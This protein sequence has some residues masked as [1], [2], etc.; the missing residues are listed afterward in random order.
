MNISEKLVLI[1]ENLKI[2]ADMINQG[3]SGDYDIGYIDGY[4]SGWNDGYDSGWWA[5][6]N[7]YGLGDNEGDMDG[8]MPWWDCP[9]CGCC[10]QEEDWGGPIYCP[11]CGNDIFSYDG[12]PPEDE[13]EGPVYDCP[14]CGSRVEAWPD[15]AN[16]VLCGGCEQWFNVDDS[17]QYWE[18]P[19][20]T[21][22]WC[23]TGIEAYP[24]EDGMI[25]CS[26]GCG[27]EVNVNDTPEE[28]ECWEGPVKYCSNCERDIH[29]YNDYCPYCGTELI[30]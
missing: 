9:H 17:G 19:V 12:P 16:E 21:C 27:N 2:M 5:C 13:W 25:T 20:Y 29:T 26:M 10:F 15:D 8:E 14:Y 3:G 11:D 30:G 18:G 28:S 22:I 23:G 1:T 4:D 7:E 24:N 6:Y